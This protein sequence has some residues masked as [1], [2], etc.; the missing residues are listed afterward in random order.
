MPYRTAHQVLAKLMQ[1]VSK[2]RVKP[3]D[4][5]VEWV[6]QTALD[7]TG[8]PL[9]ITQA[10]LA[11]ILDAMHSVRERRYRAGA[12]PE[13]VKDHITEARRRLDVDKRFLAG[14]SDRLIA[15]EHRLDGAFAALKKKVMG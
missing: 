10:E 6:E 11:R 2:E 12:A 14:T 15:S 7:Y 3:A 4:I 5:P 1:R 8:Q 13:R 9:K